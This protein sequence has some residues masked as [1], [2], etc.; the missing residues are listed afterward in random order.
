[1]VTHEDWIV[2]SP[3]MLNVV[4]NLTLCPSEQKEK[5]NWKSRLK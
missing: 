3:E 5:I 1:M 4:R 2:L